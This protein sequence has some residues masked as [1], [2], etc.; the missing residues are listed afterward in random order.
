M[1][2]LEKTMKNCMWQGGKASRLR[3]WL[4]YPLLVMGLALAC[5]RI[6]AGEA[7]Y[8]VASGGAIIASGT[9]KTLTEAVDEVND[10]VDGQGP[11]HNAEATITINSDVTVPAGAPA[12]GHQWMIEGGVGAGLRGFDSVSIVGNNHTIEGN[13]TDSSGLLG[14][15]NVD[16]TIAID[17]LTLTKGDIT[18]SDATASGAGLYLGSLDVSNAKAP[19]AITLTDVTVSNSSVVVDGVTQ[20]N[21]AMGGGIHIQAGGVNAAGTGIDPTNGS[22]EITWT[23][24]NLDGNSITLGD[25]VGGNA[26]NSSTKG[27]GG[28]VAFGKAFSYEGGEVSNNSNTL[29]NGSHAVGGGLAV[30][31][32]DQWETMNFENLTFS[33]NTTSVIGK[34]SAGHDSVARGGGLYTDSDYWDAAGSK[35][36][37]ITIDGT[38]FSNNMSS[39]EGADVSAMGGGLHMRSSADATITNTTF[40][41]NEAASTDK[42]AYG[43][44][45]ATDYWDD[46]TQYD[47]A[48]AAYNRAGAGNAISSVKLD[49]A[50]FS[51]NK[52]VGD[53]GAFGGGMYLQYGDTHSVK[54]STFDSNE[55]TS[56]NGQGLGGAIYLD[57]QVGALD[58]ADTVFKQNTASTAG[59]AIYVN[60]GAGATTLNLTSTGANSL[61]FSGNQA[62]NVANAIHFEGNGG[63]A[64]LNIGGAGDTYFYDPITA[65]VGNAAFNFNKNDAGT[66]HWGGANVFNSSAATGSTVN[67]AAGSTVLARDF[68]LGATAAGSALNV[69]M[70]AGSDVGFEGSRDK[71]VALFDLDNVTTANV[72][73]VTNNTVGI[74]LVGGLRTLDD[75]L[76]QRYLIAQN[77]N[78]NGDAAAMANELNKATITGFT[79]F[80]ADGANVY[81]DIGANPERAALLGSGYRNV[82]AS[83]DS[84]NDLV[85]AQ[86]G[87]GDFL[88]SDYEYSFVR[89]SPTLLGAD[90]I[91]NQGLAGFDMVRTMALTAR[92]ASVRVPYQAKLAMDGILGLSA[93][94]V[95]SDQANAA[96]YAQDCVFY[97]VGLRVWAGYNGYF[98][99]QD[100]HGGY[101]GYKLQQNSV[102]TGVNYDFGQVGSIGVFGGYTSATTK[103]RGMKSETDTD[104][105]HVGIAGRI[106]PFAAARGFSIYGDFSY[107]FADN[108]AWRELYGQ[109]VERNS[110]SFDQD[111]YTVGLAAEYLMRFGCFNLA[112]MLDLRYTHLRQD[113]TAETG[114]LS[115]T[116]NK[117]DGDSF[118]MRLGAEAGYDIRVGKYAYITPTLGAYWRHEFGDRQFS[119]NAMHNHQAAF[120]SFTLHSVKQDRD[121][122]DIRA[123]IKSYYD[124]GGSRIGVNLAY[125]FNISRKADSHMIYAGLEWNF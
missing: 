27:G 37:A 109:G 90:N 83:F 30:E 100:G 81:A 87:N 99:K 45:L 63:T 92:D 55:A 38:T 108:D 66:L 47:N 50:T 42:F 3:N 107:T 114:V 89:G 56:A 13:A 16:G 62:N 9:N 19:A 49:T 115:V 7:S 61:E 39:A 26:T 60:N 112:P 122:A 43:G 2:G 105:G 106:S 48:G 93:S 59:G 52:A 51:N 1:V 95:G 46:A 67:F 76:G 8:E 80:V 78:T 82:I 72:F 79:G 118:V 97:S 123:A 94:G 71:T 23:R 5:G 88:L 111:I 120:R 68:T 41:S 73:A 117:F 58:V 65:N 121:S 84:L 102:L 96:T 101:H 34:G 6:G 29:Y 20:D 124:M 25:E 33:G 116:A 86:D 21:N 12:N 32:G 53:L 125:N 35:A 104:A 24:V 36:T 75:T 119:A 31:R 85:K 15:V 113:S 22:S 91:M 44:G 57:S 40:E 110:S 54:N 4:A 77:A 10:A 18:I 70:A 98:E 103:G 14:I 11:A 28:R 64:E 69:T 74:G 17:K